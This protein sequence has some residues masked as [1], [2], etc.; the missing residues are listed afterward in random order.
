MLSKATHAG[1]ICLQCRFQLR[2]TRPRPFPA[3]TR[4][5]RFGLPRYTTRAGDE[6]DAG[7]KPSEHKEG[8]SV[9][10][11]GEDGSAPEPE[12]QPSK[13]SAPAPEAK[14]GGSFADL[15]SASKVESSGSS[16]KPAASPE[17][18]PDEPAESP[19]ESRAKIPV[20]TAPLPSKKV[21]RW[22]SLHARVEVETTSLGMDILG[23]AGHTIVIHDREPRE[24]ATPEDTD[25][26]TKDLDIKGAM[27]DHKRDTTLEETRRNIEELRPGDSRDLLARE[28]KQILDTLMGGFTS[29]QL[30]DY[31]CH[32]MGEIEGGT[33]ER[34]EAWR[35]NLVRRLTG[36]MKAQLRYPVAPRYGW[37][38]T[39]FA[40]TPPKDYPRGS[41]M[42]EKLALA[43]MRTCWHLQVMEETPYIGEMEL[44]VSKRILHLLLG[45]GPPQ[46][47]VWALLTPSTA[48]NRSLRAIQS[49][50]GERAELKVVT[51]KE[52]IQIFA[53]RSKCDAVLDQLDKFV[54]RV[55][56]ST[57]PLSSLGPRRLTGEDLAQLSSLTGAHVAY[58]SSES[59]AAKSQ[60]KRGTLAKPSE[61]ESDQVWRLPAFPS[62]LH[63]DRPF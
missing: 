59:A 8:E 21:P 49:A 10:P 35:R 5:A 26:P 61:K 40:W 58:A 60:A 15:I 28:S 39:Q 41:T 62:E 46:P 43:I 42:K 29:S 44:H 18:N 3:T 16:Y 11:A 34:S 57:I 1:R 50:L 25:E 2:L 12:A 63:T 47:L 38:R 33:A 9:E 6:A 56:E 53:T 32:F 20:E 54:S 36:H 7:K 31:I 14:T 30:E 24:R 17:F 13:E 22:R 51:E 45:K 55:Q 52:K 37:I 19:V 48:E 23:K 27:E 4:L